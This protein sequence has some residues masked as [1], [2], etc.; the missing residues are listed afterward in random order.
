M[1][2][3]CSKG[4]H[5][6]WPQDYGTQLGEL[7]NLF[8]PINEELELCFLGLKCKTFGTFVFGMP[9]WL[10]KRQLD[11]LVLRLMAQWFPEHSAWYL[12]TGTLNLNVSL[13]YTPCSFVRNLLPGV[14]TAA[15][16]GPGSLNFHPNFHCTCSR[17]QPFF[18]LQSACFW[19][20]LKKRNLIETLQP[21]CPYAKCDHEYG[22]YTM[23]Q[24]S[25]HYNCSINKQ[26][27]NA[28][29][30]GLCSISVAPRGISTFINKSLKSLSN[31]RVLHTT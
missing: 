21:P 6:L 4:S 10:L 2:K 27:H 31:Q 3:S 29:T 26:N 30:W 9:R 1:N 22:T 16:S 14:Q 19:S 24:M 13:R 5:S 12:Q 23:I 25:W 7:H 20:V 28:R 11:A 8:L 18:A 17:Q 15:L